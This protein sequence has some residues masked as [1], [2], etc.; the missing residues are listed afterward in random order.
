MSEEKAPALEEYKPTRLEWLVVML[1]SLISRNNLKQDNIAFFFLPGEDGKSIDLNLRHYA[2]M[3]EER[4]ASV[5]NSIKDLVFHFAEG[6]E[7]N[8]SIEFKTNI[9]KIDR[10]NERE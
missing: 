6:L 7:G 4:I 3:D 8:L 5:I 10:E 2:D 1:N 9:H